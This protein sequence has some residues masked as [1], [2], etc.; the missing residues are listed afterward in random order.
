MP[1]KKKTTTTPADIPTPTPNLSVN[2]PDDP[3]MTKIVKVV[4]LTRNARLPQRRSE[5][6]AGFDLCTI[7]D[8]CIPPI[9]ALNFPVVI[10][11]GLAFAIP[12]GYHMKIFLRSS[13]GARSKLRLA[14]QTGIIDSDYRGELVL[15]LE[16]LSRTGFYLSA[17]TRIAQCM[18]ERHVPV[19]FEE[20]DAL[21]KTERGTGGI[22]STGEA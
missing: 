20:V 16:N 11:T 9:H 10:H 21:D 4:R 8:D 1:A 19:V 7:L 3:T 17:G 6:S 12:E 14:N 5:G 13:I 2:L 18:I 15:I 22:G